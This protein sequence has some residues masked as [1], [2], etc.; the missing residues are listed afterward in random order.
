MLFWF[1]FLLRKVM[2][3]LMA[4]RYNQVL[5]L[6]SALKLSIFTHAFTNVSWRISLASSC[7]STIFRICQYSLSLYSDTSFANAWRAVFGSRTSSSNCSSLI[8]SIS[9][10]LNAKLL[11]FFNYYQMS[12]PFSNQITKFTA[13]SGFCCHHSSDSG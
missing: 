5:S 7:E 11:F 12:S 8:I 4:I 9:L 10:D 6:D 3:S 13:A 2:L 1:L